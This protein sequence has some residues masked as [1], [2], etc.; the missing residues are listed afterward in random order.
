MVVGGVGGGGGGVGVGG[1]G[2]LPVLWARYRGQKVAPHHGVSASPQPPGNEIVIH[3]SQQDRPRHR[4]RTPHWLQLAAWCPVCLCRHMSTTRRLV[5]DV[6]VQTLEH[7]S[8]LGVRGD[9]A[10][11]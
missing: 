2:S 3:R 9:C 11:T 6:S 8:P 5:S 7:N 1:G 10:Y 4:A